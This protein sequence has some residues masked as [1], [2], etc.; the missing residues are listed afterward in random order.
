MA[1]FYEKRNDFREFHKAPLLVQ[2]LDDIFIYNARMVNY[3]YKGIYF[4]SDAELKVG[5]KII[6]G[7]EDLTYISPSAST[8][9]PKFYHAIILWKKDLTGSIFNFGYGTKFVY[10]SDHQ[11]LPNTDSILKEEYRKYPRKPYSQK[12]I[13]S[14]AQNYYKGSIGNI[15]RG[16]AFIET[17]GK[18][19]KGQIIKLTIP[20]TKI[21]NGRM[22][23]TQVIHL[24]QSGAGVS[25]KGIINKKSNPKQ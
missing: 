1:R 22:L 9:S 18:I 23:V 2:E 16:G 15:S 20:G 17:T 21:D 4:E 5:N 3:N 24:N 13:L 25:F 14:S 11:N 7:L 19:K 10:F 12:V 8:D 6:I